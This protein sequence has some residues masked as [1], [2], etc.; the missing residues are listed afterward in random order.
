MASARRPLTVVTALILGVLATTPAAHAADYV[1]TDQTTC[2]AFLDASEVSGHA[3]SLFCYVSGGSTV[4]ADDV[5]TFDGD[6][7]LLRPTG[8][9]TVVNKGHVTV[10]GG[11]GLYNTTLLVNQGV[12]DLD[13][14]SL[15]WRPVDNSGTV[16]VSAQTHVLPDGSGLTNSGAVLVTSTGRLSVAAPFVNDGVVGVACGGRIDL[17]APHLFTGAAPSFACGPTG[18]VLSGRSVL[19]LQPAGTVVGTLGAAQAQPAGPY[20]YT[21]LVGADEFAV[22]GSSLVTAGPL[23]PGPHQVTVRVTDVHGA[24]KDEAFT[25]VADNPAGD[26]RI[27]ATQPAP[28]VSTPRGGRARR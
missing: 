10:T 19:P 11:S 9:G 18:V 2:A 3:G 7:I 20:T 1:V 5:I 12:L 15:L 24:W 8:P 4:P 6:Q 13:G 23:S 17:S 25:V 16:S 26:P 22:A 28:P 27:T 14:A 21:V